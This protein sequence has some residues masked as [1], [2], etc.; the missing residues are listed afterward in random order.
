MLT[1]QSER[2]RRDIEAIIREYSGCLTLD[3]QAVIRGKTFQGHYGPALSPRDAAKILGVSHPTVV[4]WVHDGRLDGAQTV[5]DVKHEGRVLAPLDG[6]P[7]E[8]YLEDILMYKRTGLDRLERMNG[9]KYEIKLE[10]LDNYD[11]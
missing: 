5:C 9:K 11:F 6:A 7:Y 1:M 10:E 4:K 3:E 8:I 2:L